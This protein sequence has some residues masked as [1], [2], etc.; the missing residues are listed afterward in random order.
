MAGK[1]TRSKKLQAVKEEAEDLN[2]GGAK[3]DLKDLEKA[4]FTLLKNSTYASVDNYVPTGLPALD[5]TMGGGIPLSRITQFFA[6]NGVG[7]SM[8][9]IQIVKH[10]ISMELPVVYLDTEGTFSSQLL[11]DMGVDSSKVFVKGTTMQDPEGLTIEALGE[12]IEAAID[13]FDKYK[14]PIIFIYDSVGASISR[15]TMEKDFGDEQPGIQAKAITKLIQKVAPK[16]TASN[17]ALILLNQIRQNI[18]GGPFSSVNV[19]GGEALEHSLSLNYQMNRLGQVK[20]GDKYEGHKVKFKN[21]KSKVSTPFQEA[22]QF[23][24]G[25][26]GFN[27]YVNT[28]YT[29]EQLKLITIPSAGGKKIRVPNKET[30]E[31]EIFSYYDFLDTIATPEGAEEYMYFLKPLFQK[32]VKHYFPEEFPPLKN[33]DVNVQLSPLYEGI[34][35]IYKEDKKEE[36]TKASTEDE[37]E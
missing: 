17:S 26:D 29:A 10:A 19:P 18:G 8:L 32:I 16:I 9:A 21:K 14:K 27:E 25:G 2:I 1:T 4:G 23:L 12:S 6:S 15:K 36:D 22:E 28:I 37:V 7:K 35:D 24:Y 34:E 5:V 31:V 3:L 30:G 11:E 33:K 20:K 13:L